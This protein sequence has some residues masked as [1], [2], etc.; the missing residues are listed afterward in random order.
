MEN[1]FKEEIKI[2]I[3]MWLCFCFVGHIQSPSGFNELDMRGDSKVHWC[4]G[5][6]HGEFPSL[7]FQ[8]KKIVYQKKQKAKT[9][10]QCKIRIPLIIRFEI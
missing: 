6:C 3:S 8:L 1:N 7:P 2:I 5:L 10:Q 9:Q 4:S